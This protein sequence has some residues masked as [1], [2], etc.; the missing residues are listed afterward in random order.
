M[1]LGGNGR[2]T[3]ESERQT[4]T[5]PEGGK[6][7]YWAHVETEEDSKATYDTFA[8]TVDGKTVDQLSNLDANSGYE[9]RT[10]DLSSYSGRRVTLS[11]SAR[12]DAHAKTSFVVDDVAVG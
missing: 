9:Q 8:V 6:L 3:S 1:W 10:V 4:V 12:E 5:V 11:F 7:T 2:S